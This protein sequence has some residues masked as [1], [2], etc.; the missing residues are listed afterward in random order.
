MKTITAP[1]PLTVRRSKRNTQ[2][3][4]PLGSS[5][6]AQEVNEKHSLDSRMDQTIPQSA[7]VPATNNFAETSSE[8]VDKDNSP[9]KACS[10][11]EWEL[12][13]LL[14]LSMFFEENACEGEK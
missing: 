6:K 5:L 7:N 11:W 14:F 8:I 2:T 13:Y 9:E 4:V 3:T 1:S 10:D 12:E